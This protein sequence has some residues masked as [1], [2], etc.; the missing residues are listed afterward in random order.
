MAF[1]H[2]MPTPRACN[3]PK[4]TTA[5]KRR[6]NKKKKDKQSQSTTTSQSEAA[7]KK[8]KTA[9][10][11]DEAREL[12]ASIVKLHKGSHLY[13]LFRNH[14]ACLFPEYFR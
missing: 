10:E 3:A 4:A 2:P 8:L 12:T 9:T 13:P 5:A 14:H 6:K 7:L 11:V 1:T